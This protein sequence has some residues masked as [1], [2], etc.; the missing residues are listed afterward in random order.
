MMEDTL[1]SA[2]KSEPTDQLNP[3]KMITTNESWFYTHAT[4]NQ[5]E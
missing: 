5:W 4:D 1:S 3:Y 2:N